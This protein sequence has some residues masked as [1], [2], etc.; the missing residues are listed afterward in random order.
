MPDAGYRELLV[1]VGVEEIPSRYLDA[2]AAHFFKGMTE[3]LRIVRLDFRRESIWSTPRRLGFYA[4]VA[5]AQTAQ[6]E[7]V[8]GPA[9]ATAWGKDGPTPAL[10][11]F[12][13]RV[14]VSI[15]DL[16]RQM[17]GTNEYV[18]A[19]LAKPIKRAEDVLPSL[20]EDVL[21]EMPKPRTMRWDGSDA[22]FVRPVRWLV[23]LLDDCLLHGEALG[24]RAGT[25][26][27]G[28]RTDHPAS[29]TV[30]SIGDYWRAM[31]AGKVEVD[32]KRRR[33]TIVEEG[34]RLAASVGGRIDFE[35][36]LLEEVAN[37]VE[38]PTPFLGEFS[39]DFLHIPAP[40]LV[41]SMRV[42][43]RYF[44]V[45]DPNGVLLPFFLAVR[46]GMGDALDLVRHGNEKVLR[47]R[48]S[49]AQYF[50]AAD[51]KT[52][53]ADH[54]VALAHVTLHT[55]IG[56][57]QDKVDRIQALFART[58]EWWHL[59]AEV[60]PLFMRSVD[61]Y[62]C[63]LLTQV[64]GEFPELQG[65]MGGIYAQLD[66][67]DGR[68]VAAIADQYRP[69][70][71]H[72]RLPQEPV[73]Q[74]LGLLDRIDTLVAFFAAGIRPS[75]SEDPF[76]LRRVALGLALL[77]TRTP[78]LGE[79]TITELLAEAGRVATVN[80][81]VVE[82]VQTL[83]VARLISALEEQWPVELLQ[84]VLDRDFPWTRLDS[85]LRFLKTH[86][87][88]ADPVIAAFKRVGKLSR[89]VN[90]GEPLALGTGIESELGHV[91]QRAL[92]IETDNLQAWWDII[93]TM[94]VL[95]EQFFT[96]VLVMDPD[97]EVRHRRLVLLQRVHQ[98]LGR[99]CDW[100]KL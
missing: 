60:E 89:G 1:E 80:A 98:A 2:L 30:R 33:Q 83:V 16:G 85:R 8:R 6:Q 58:R 10:M 25:Q 59:G 20:V 71:A 82:D 11:G 68:V 26:T 91:A 29:L 41:T 86:R 52:R 44:P 37:L 79:H 23:M 21:T 3:H 39:S 69:A 34:T 94:P 55:K 88:E 66:G 43:Q 96:E 46:N 14:G 7:M 49:D 40:I 100:E 92:A 62:K 74:L 61:L 95:I 70:Y 24:V 4:E 81:A 27:F 56:T 78:I 50:F 22:R 65:E 67:E 84:A 93:V 75:G 77:A 15:D 47:A 72:D 35:G 54:R 13:R 87:G 53:L 28:N 12:V 31:A 45:R 57:Y 99:Y 5:P 36:G 48:L 64:V 97:L 32:V 19:S 63:D 76:G 38:W 17:V 73:A 18:T 51:R 42:H 9:V 90:G